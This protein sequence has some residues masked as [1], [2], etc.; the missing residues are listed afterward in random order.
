[1][2]YEPDW[3]LSNWDRLNHTIMVIDN[4]DDLQFL[5]DRELAGRKRPMY[6][7]RIHSRLNK[8]RAAR[9]RADILAVVG[10]TSLARID[11][12]PELQRYLRET[13]PA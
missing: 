4:E 7:F 1:M 6:A 11:V 8:M 5:L 3:I 9:E 2:S 10:D 12:Y 13:E